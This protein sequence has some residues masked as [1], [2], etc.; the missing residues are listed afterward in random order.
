MY[1]VAMFFAIF[2]LSFSEYPMVLARFAVL[3]IY[4]RTAADNLIWPGC[5]FYVHMILFYVLGNFT[6]WCK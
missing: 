4:F 2:I 1:V 5:P 3:C 6:L